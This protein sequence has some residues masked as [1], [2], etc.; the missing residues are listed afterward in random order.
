M[1]LIPWFII[2]FGAYIKI[3]AKVGGAFQIVSISKVDNPCQL[4]GQPLPVG[5][6]LKNR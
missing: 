6:E 3:G 4:V 1:G 2:D 5:K